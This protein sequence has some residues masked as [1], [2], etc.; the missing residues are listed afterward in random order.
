MT[1]LA[2]YAAAHR[3][4]PW[5]LAHAY[6]DLFQRNRVWLRQGARPADGVGL[7]CEYDA[8][9]RPRVGRN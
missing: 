1:S 6:G 5:T 4:I 2:E 7:R 3:L 9:E 8:N